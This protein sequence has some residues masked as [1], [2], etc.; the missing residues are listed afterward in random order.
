MGIFGERLQQVSAEKTAGSDQNYTH[1]TTSQAPG[2]PW[3]VRRPVA[4]KQRLRL[5]P[6]MKVCAVQIR[7][8]GISIFIVSEKPG[9][10]A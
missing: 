1:V 9:W 2:N 6:S 10:P 3:P 5:R 4:S 8:L 7:R